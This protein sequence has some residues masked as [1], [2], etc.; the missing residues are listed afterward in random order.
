MTV[1][2]GAGGT[3][4]DERNPSS[5]HACPSVDGQEASDAANKGVGRRRLLLGGG[6]AAASAVVSI[7]PALAQTAASVLHCQIPVPDPSRSGQAI[8]ADG[9][10]VP[11]G[12]QGAFPASGRPF[13]GEEVKAALRGRTL[14]GT[15]YEQSRA[16]LNYIRRLQSGTSGFT[17]YASLQMP[18]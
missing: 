4:M 1:F 14:P 18:R 7:R 17:C 2:E 6:L 13:T 15:T 16:Y 3:D 11:A 9:S 8:A 12:T 5:S 10:L